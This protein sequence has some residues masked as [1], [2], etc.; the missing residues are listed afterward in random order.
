MSSGL[1]GHWKFNEKSGIITNDSSRYHNTGTLTGAT[2][3]KWGEKGIIFDG[4]DDYVD[5]GNDISVREIGNL[6]V[7][8]WVYSN[9]VIGNKNILGKDNSAGRGW[10]FRFT[11]NVLQLETDGSVNVVQSTTVLS[12][13]TWYF[14]AFT[15]TNASG[16]KQDF[17]LYIN[18]RADTIENENK[19]ILS[20]INLN[21][22]RRAYSGNEEYWSGLIAEARIYNRALSQLEIKRLYN[23]TKHKYI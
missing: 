7:A 14:V 11:G 20:P 22:G 17:I 16:T 3:P 1:V 10:T 21:I 8:A 13:N 18:G 4:V 19:L 2:L 15:A 6:T 12:A 23:S 9:S 5:A